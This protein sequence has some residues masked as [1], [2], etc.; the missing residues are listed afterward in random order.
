VLKP[1][2]GSWSATAAIPGTQRPPMPK[3]LK[4]NGRRAP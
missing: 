1:A 2:A 4:L 3:W